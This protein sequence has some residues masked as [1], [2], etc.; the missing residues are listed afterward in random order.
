GIA[1]R[2]RKRADYIRRGERSYQRGESRVGGW[3]RSGAA[4][5]KVVGR[6]RVSGRVVGREPVLITVH[7]RDW[8]GER[9]VDESRASAAGRSLIDGHVANQ[10]VAR[11]PLPGSAPMIGAD[12]PACGVVESQA[13]HR[14]L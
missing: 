4:V 8:V 3:R 14:K 7:E 11:G 12:R 9:D 5:E 6:T 10:E 13:D 1:R 2:F